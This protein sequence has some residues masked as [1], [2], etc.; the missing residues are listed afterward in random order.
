MSLPSRGGQTGD[1]GGGGND[2]NGSEA[3]PSRFPVSVIMLI[4][5]HF[6]REP[7]AEA[8]D[9][10]DKVFSRERGYI[11]SLQALTCL[12]ESSEGRYSDDGGD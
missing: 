9:P 4:K 11:W 6:L 2:G 1:R 12:D 8:D 7:E 10:R 5:D 3:A